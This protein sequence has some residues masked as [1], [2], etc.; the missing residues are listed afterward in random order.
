MHFLL[1]SLLFSHVQERS[2]ISKKFMFYGLLIQIL[3]LVRNFFLSKFRPSKT[4]IE[5]EL[6]EFKSPIYLIFKRDHL[7]IKTNSQTGSWSFPDEK[8]KTEKMPGM[9]KE[10]PSCGYDCSSCSGARKRGIFRIPTY[11]YK[12]T[13]G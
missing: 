8:S 4:F 6:T 11:R 3:E 2:S 1:T 13:V 12:S 7:A 9:Q 5:V 10:T